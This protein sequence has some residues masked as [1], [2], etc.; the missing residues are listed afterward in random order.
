MRA[1]FPLGSLV[2]IV[3]SS[4]LAGCSLTPRQTD[5]GIPEP[6]GYPANAK[7][8][9]KNQ[10]TANPKSINPALQQT[11][12]QQ[13]SQTILQLLQQK[14]MPSL[15]SFVHPQQGV[16]FSPYVHVSAQDLRFLPSQLA[17]LSTD[18]TIYHWGTFDGSGE[19][20]QL[21][22]NGYWQKFIFSHDYTS[23]RTQQIVNQPTQRGNS[24]NTIK[25]FYPG[26]MMVEYHR[27]ATTG[28]PLDWSS[29]ILVFQPYQ[30]RWYLVGIVH[31]Q[32]TI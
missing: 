26:S 20:I 2:I 16:R 10:S 23:S 11:Q 12:P 25:P 27:P 6:A 3:G 8:L 31:D 17:Q 28:Q 7:N 4:L 14:N 9:P 22:F 5:H 24:L 18:Q 30:G 32:W 13:L 15:A 29:L 21:T 19:P 1:H